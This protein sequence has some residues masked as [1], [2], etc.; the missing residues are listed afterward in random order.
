M[1]KT[2]S[3]DIDDK[4]DFEL[5]IC[6]QTQRTKKQILLNTIHNRIAEKQEKMK[7]VSDITLI[8]GH[9]IFDYW[10]IEKLSNQSINN[11]GIAGISSKEYLDLS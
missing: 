4:L 9:S 11:L 10:N 7:L 5:A 8:I 2:D 1:N 6:I 3:V